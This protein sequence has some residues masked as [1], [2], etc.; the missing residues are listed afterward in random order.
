MKIFGREPVYLLA[1]VAIA[2]KLAAAYGLDVSAGQQG[3]IMA[4]LSLTV[5]LVTAVVLK[6]GAAAAAVVNFAQGALALF[7][8]FGLELSAD[9]QALWMAGVEAAVALVLRKEVTAPVASLRV[10]QSSVVKAA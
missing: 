9:Q 5:A 3:A 7:L 2:L 6:T 8:A 4:V 10:E 1:F